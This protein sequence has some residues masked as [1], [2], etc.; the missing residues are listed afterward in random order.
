LVVVVVMMMMKKQ[1]QREMALQC[2]VDKARLAPK[3]GEA[4]QV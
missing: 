3:L 1:G 2:T 4:V